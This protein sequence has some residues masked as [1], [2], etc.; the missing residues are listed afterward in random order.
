MSDTQSEIRRLQEERK[1]NT[2]NQNFVDR[3]SLTGTGEYDSEIYGGKDKSQYLDAVPAADDE[4]DDDVI[5]TRHPSTRS[6]INPSRAL[7]AES[8]GGDDDGMNGHYREQYGS[9]LVN[10]RISDRENEVRYSNIFQR[11]LPY[12]F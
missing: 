9:G 7:V 6:R 4:D 11:A 5:D 1:T 12:F 2:G 3:I 8:I 10:T